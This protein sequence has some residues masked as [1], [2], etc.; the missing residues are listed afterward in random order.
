[1]YNSKRKPDYSHTKKTLG[2]VTLLMYRYILE[3]V[4]MPNA[5]L[6]E[7]KQSPVYLQCSTFETSWAQRKT[8]WDSMSVEQLARG[9]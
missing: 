9:V 8:V 7:E 6:Y 2:I 5:E 4:K 3:R 1:M